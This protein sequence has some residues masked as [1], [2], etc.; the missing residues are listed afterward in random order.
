MENIIHIIFYNVLEHGKAIFPSQ[1][2]FQINKSTMHSFIEIVEK[3]KYCIEGKKYSCCEISL[4][5]EKAF[6]TV[7]HNILLQT[8]YRY[9]I[10]GTTLKWFP[11]PLHKRSQFV[12]YKNTLSETN[13]ITC[14]VAQGSILG[15]LLFLL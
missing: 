9:G 7:N 3:I 11:S 1:F 2:G 14:G 13:Y 4:D 12:S 6:D 10:R 5:L 15:A 8:L